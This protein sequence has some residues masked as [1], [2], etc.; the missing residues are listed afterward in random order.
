MLPPK[1]QKTKMVLK[2]K[3]KGVFALELYQD[4]TIHNLRN[5]FARL[6]GK[7]QDLNQSIFRATLTDFL[8][9]L[10]LFRIIIH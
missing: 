1:P 8:A 7:Y 2:E 9:L 4:L 3:T 10:G 5:Q 6:F